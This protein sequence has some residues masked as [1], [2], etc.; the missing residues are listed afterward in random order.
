MKS[1][2]ILWKL[3]VVLLDQKTVRSSEIQLCHLWQAN[4]LLFCD[5]SKMDDYNIF[6]CF[7]HAVFFL[8]K[9][10]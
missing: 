5:F 1:L 3:L 4:F 9:F 2:L 10:V 7:F 6:R 8:L